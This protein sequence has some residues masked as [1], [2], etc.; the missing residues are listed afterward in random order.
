MRNNVLAATGI[1]L[2]ALVL[3]SIS[4]ESAFPGFWALL[5]TMSTY[6]IIAAGPHAWLNSAVLASRPCRFIG[7]ISYPLY[8]WHWPLLSFARILNGGTPPAIVQC[9]TDQRG[10]FSRLADFSNRGAANLAAAADCH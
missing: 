2:L 7:I 6:L 9:C 8:L 10:N 4:P 5:P 3:V 1:V